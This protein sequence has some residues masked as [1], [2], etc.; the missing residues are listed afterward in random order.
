MFIDM[1]IYKNEFTSIKKMATNN[2]MLVQYFIDL[3][4][5]YRRK[6]DIDLSKKIYSYDEMTEE[7]FNEISKKMNLKKVDWPQDLWQKVY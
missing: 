7:F 6:L 2:L 3:Y 1:I 4:Q 5:Q